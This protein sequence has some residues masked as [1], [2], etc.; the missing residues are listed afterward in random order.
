MPYTEIKRTKELNEKR[1]E[2]PLY[3]KENV[4]MHSFLPSRSLAGG[5]VGEVMRPVGL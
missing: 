3:E 1:N 2:A 4:P 5:A